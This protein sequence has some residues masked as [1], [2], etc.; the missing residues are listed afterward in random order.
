MQ[1]LLLFLF[2]L[3]IGSSLFAQVEVNV[4]LKP[5]RNSLTAY[6]MAR[7]D[8]QSNL[9]PAAQLLQDFPFIGKI[10]ASQSLRTAPGAAN[11]PLKRLFTLRINAPHAGQVIAELQQSGAFEWVEANRTV[12]LHAIEADPSD[13]DSVNIQWYHSYVKTFEA[14]E[15]TK[16]DSTV[17]VG[18]IDTGLD[19]EHPEFKRQ[20]A[21]N[22]GE[23]L[24][25]NG[26]YEPWAS[27]EV[28]NGLTGDFDGKDSDG[29]GYTD[30][31]VGYDF[32]DQ[33]RSPFGGDFLNDDP[34]PAD[35]NRHGTLVAGV[36]HAKDNNR[37]GGTGLAPNTRLVVLR[38]FSASGQGEDDDIARAIIYA[39][40]NGVKVLN[41]SFGDIYPS[42]MMH[43]AIKYAYSRGVIMVGSAGN[44]TGDE[45][46][47]PS[48]FN[49]VIS[50]SASTYDPSADGREFLWPLSSYGVTV[51]M[52]AP[53][54]RILTPTILDTSIT[55]EITQYSRVQGTSFAAPM[56]AAAAA[57]LASTRPALTPQ[58]AR[59]ILVSSTDD[60]SSPGWDHFTGAGRL[61]I[62]K[63]LQTV[64][65]SLVQ[66]T[67]PVNDRGTDADSI[68]IIGTILDP[69]FSSWS[70][71]FQ[72][73]LEGA[74]DWVSLLEGQQIQ[75]KEDTLFLW[76]LD[77]L[78]EGEYTLR[79][80]VERSNGFPVEDR[81]R[82]VRETTPPEIDIKL[83]KPIWDN[84]VR[85]FLILY[86][87]SDQGQHIL[88]FRPK[89]SE[90][91]FRQLAFDRITRNGEFL[92]DNQLLQ[93]GEYDFFIEATNLAGMKGQT[94]IQSFTFEAD[95]V[96]RAGFNLLDYSLPMGRFLE[97]TYDFNNNG[98][99]E[100]VM[101]EYDEQL[102]F[103]RTMFYE[104]DGFAFQKRDSIAFR[105]VS[106]PKD[107]ADT[108]GDGL[109]ELLCSANDSA[110]VLEQAAPGLFPKESI[111]ENLGEGY[112]AARWGDIDDDDELELLMKDFVH[113]YVFEGKGDTYTLADSLKDFSGNFMGSIA[114]RLLVGDFDGDEIT[115]T[116][117]GDFDGDFLVFEPLFNGRYQ[118]VF[119][120]TTSLTKSGSY[121]CQ[122]DF[123]GDGVEDFFIAT[124]SSQLR[125]ADFEYDAPYWR[126]RIFAYEKDNEFEVIWEDYLYDIDIDRF[127]GATAGNIDQDAASELIFSTYPRTYIIDFDQSTN[128]LGMKWFLYGSLATHHIIADFNNNS[129]NEFGIGRGD[130]TFFWELDFDYTG[131]ELVTSLD[132]I[133]LGPNKILLNWPAS[134]R[135]TAYDVFQVHVDSAG[136]PLFTGINT[137]RFLTTDDMIVNEPYR[138]FA[139]ATDGMQASPFGNQVI[140]IPHENNRLDSI[141]VINAR[142]I[143]L[144]FSWPVTDRP[145][146][147]PY[148]VLNGEH[149]PAAITKTGDVGNRLILSFEEP[150][151]VGMN[152]LIIDSLFLDA[153]FGIFNPNSPVFT[154]EYTP[155]E[156]D[157][158]YLTNWSVADDQQAELTFNYAV[159][160]GALEASNYSVFPF[161]QAVSVS[162]ANPE[163]SAV[164]VTVDQVTLGSLGYPV[165]IVV[166]P[167]VCAQNGTCIRAGEGNTATFSSFQ[168]DL[169]KVYVYPNPVRPTPLFE[170][171]RFANLTQTAS[172]RIMNASGRMV[173]ELKETDGDGGLTWNMQDFR[174]E[175]IPPGV[176]LYFVTD[177]SGKEF[178]GKFSV[179]E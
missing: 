74:P 175:R 129:V 98:F 136:G 165:S 35:D 107:V 66:I 111:Y 50:V 37:L 33:P 88:N 56:V 133:V 130:T 89:G 141:E 73:G 145:R 126:L 172:I 71:E 142:Q 63:A 2:S 64:G 103:G 3:L 7:S 151:E 1:R 122:G 147:I 157:F 159:G 144:R 11:T 99:P 53:G 158:L 179:I 112:F 72:R 17:K 90:E 59:G 146:D 132:A 51:D 86:R 154:F 18:V 150:F 68:Y 32:T 162:Y 143:A 58:Q 105:E 65:A 6:L 118:P 43:E 47:Y 106:I 52:C 21:I 125:N 30:D 27:T 110:Y 149:S 44:G 23:D 39:A 94:A 131:P 34:H 19:F 79:L 25:G 93:N 155:T 83:A 13:D 123:D 77:T 4:K 22:A 36:I 114:P 167:E 173:T 135:A 109:L 156:E 20:I 15:I 10:T 76:R 85:K 81:I 164:L 121:A 174:G 31:V 163:Q 95:F 70:L 48:G 104:F 24:N 28:R 161:G 128:S 91:P 116:V 101:N 134:A 166:A 127:N 113:Y 138:F 75:T 57:L 55:G 148:F 124:H 100:V 178:M 120:D 54:A 46:H 96:N 78:P 61:N 97:Q 82:F 45:L 69:Q 9:R 171:L 8:Q 140:R 160:P 119:I 26:T 102:A 139:R 49:E 16:G 42:R 41:L 29:N 5:E 170:G 115:E 92:L 152:A 14:W 60:I 67:S 177:G 40:D 38:A 169:S 117:F 153:D 62:L 168:E 80:R 12:S 87:D 176:Y 108:D 137:T 84:E